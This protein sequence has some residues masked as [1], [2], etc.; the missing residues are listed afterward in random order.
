MKKRFALDSAF[1]PR[2]RRRKESPKNGFLTPFSPEA[3]LEALRRSVVRGAPFGEAWWQ[4]RT[5]KRLGL[6]S[7]LRARGR[8]WKSPP[9]AA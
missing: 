7:T 1:R 3:E 2:G 9:E 6:Q 5:A 4:E 8:P